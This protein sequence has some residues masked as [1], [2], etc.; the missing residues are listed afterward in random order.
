MDEPVT[1]YVRAEYST[2]II[3]DIKKVEKQFNI[4]WEKDVEWFHVKWGKL[5]VHGHNG[6]VYEFD[7]Q[8]EPGEIDW[9]RPGS[10]DLLGEDYEY[11]DEYN[12][13]N[14]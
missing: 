9:K 13:T 12:G 1:R 10:T 4:N 5:I 3:F 2:A 7:T 8:E 11:I 6:S 14:Q